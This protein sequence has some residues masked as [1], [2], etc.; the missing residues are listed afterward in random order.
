MQKFAA[1]TQA[2]ASR[3][4][5]TSITLPKKKTV[6]KVSFVRVF[7]RPVLNWAGG[8]SLCLCNPVSGKEIMRVVVADSKGNLL[9]LVG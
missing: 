8:E 9:V 3:I 6:K 1:Q 5:V 7:K 4:R 2:S